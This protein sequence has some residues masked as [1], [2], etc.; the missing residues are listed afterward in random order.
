[1]RRPSTLIL[2]VISSRN[3]LTLIIVKVGRHSQH[4]SLSK[5]GVFRQRMFLLF[6]CFN[7]IG[8]LYCNTKIHRWIPCLPWPCRYMLENKNQLWLDHQQKLSRSLTTFTIELLWLQLVLCVFKIQVP[9][10]MVLFDN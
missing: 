1:M 4:F 7:H 9:S 2:I 6:F 3:M 5:G 10:L 8:E